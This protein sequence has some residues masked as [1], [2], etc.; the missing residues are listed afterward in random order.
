LVDDFRITGRPS[1]DFGFVNVG[2]FRIT[3]PL[4][5]FQALAQ[6]RMSEWF[7]LEYS[8]YLLNPA[9][10]ILAELMS[11]AFYD[12]ELSD[13][14]TEAMDLELLLVYLNLAD[15]L[16]EVFTLAFYDAE[17]SDTLS[18][19]I[20]MAL[21]N[22]PWPFSDS[23]SEAVAMALTN[24]PWPFSDSISESMAAKL[25]A[26]TITETLSETMEMILLAFS[27]SDTLSESMTVIGLLLPISDTISES[28]HL[29][30]P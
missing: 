5:L 10:D 4:T 19:A 23:L 28:M 30:S 24:V 15:S 29:T 25:I 20:A 13:T 11:L 14:L 16:S 3:T 2:E 18:E 12:A 22:V 17:L 26:F 8:S 9:P 27:V 21:T 6:D 1:G 7:D